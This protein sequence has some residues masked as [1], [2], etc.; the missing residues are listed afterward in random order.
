MDDY[1]DHGLDAIY[2][3]EADQTLYLVQ[4]KMKVDAHFTLGEAQ[5]FIEGIKLLLN[6]QFNRFNQKNRTKTFKHRLK[7][8]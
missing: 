1:E 5:A 2:Y 4:S 6:K 8:H 3:H 7:R